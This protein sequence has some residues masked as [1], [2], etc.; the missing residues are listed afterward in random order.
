HGPAAVGD[1][2]VGPA[3]LARGLVGRLGGGGA[4]HTGGPGGRGDESADQ[5]PLHV[6][7]SPVVHISQRPSSCPGLSATKHLKRTRKQPSSQ[8]SAP[9]GPR[10]ARTAGTRR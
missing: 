4:A 6:L 8:V 9:P 10:A 2:R 1:A 3:V 7:S 5:D